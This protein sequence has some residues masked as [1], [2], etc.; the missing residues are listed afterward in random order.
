MMMSVSIDLH[1]LEPMTQNRFI[2]LGVLRAW[3]LLVCV[4]IG[5][6]LELLLVRIPLRIIEPREVRNDRH[7]RLETGENENRGSR[8]HDVPQRFEILARQMIARTSHLI[9]GIGLLLTCLVDRVYGG[10][11][12]GGGV[13]VRH[14]LDIVKLQ[15]LL[16]RERLTNVAN[17]AHAKVDRRSLF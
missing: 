2:D 1:P 11:A 16:L 3:I 9:D 13:A 6:I 15:D 12:D 14:R 10:V 8:H 5:R 17:V 7:Q 4:H